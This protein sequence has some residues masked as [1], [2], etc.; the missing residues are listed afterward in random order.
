MSFL[1]QLLFAAG[2]ENPPATKPNRLLLIVLAEISCLLL[3]F[4]CYAANPPPDVNEAHYLAKAKHYW[5]PDWLA[6][7]HFLE[8]AD[9][10][11]VFYWTFGWLTLWFPLPVVAW[12]GRVVTWLGLAFAIRRMGRGV[13]PTPFFAVLVGAL[14]VVFLHHF[15]M[16]G[17][18]LIGGVEAKGFAFVFVFLALDCL[19]RK[20]IELAVVLCGVAAAFHVLVGGWSMIAMVAA[21]LLEGKVARNYERMAYALVGGFFCSLPGLLPAVM[22]TSNAPAGIIARANEIYVYERLS[23]HLVPSTFPTTNAFGYEWVSWAILRFLLLTICWYI[24]W[25]LSRRDEQQAAIHRFV[26][27][28]C[29]IAAAG[30]VLNA[31]SFTW[32]DR[33]ASLLRLYWFRLSDFAVPLGAAIVVAKV[34][35]SCFTKGRL[36]RVLASIGL[37]PLFL[38]FAGSL[39]NRVA[40]PRPLGD[41][42]PAMVSHLSLPEKY[43]LWQEWKQAMAFIR[44]HTPPDAR[45]I[46]P[47]SQQTFKWYAHR[48]EVVN[49]KDVPQNASALVEW[50]DRMREVFPPDWELYGMTVHDDEDIIRIGDKYGASYLLTYRPHY[51]RPPEFERIYPK[52]NRPANFE[53][54]KIPPER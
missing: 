23:H 39:W 19:V 50:S 43:E 7:D 51:R 38:S 41:Q 49:W 30:F 52:H 36:V 54:Y 35:M 45:F 53:L 22:L 33:G 12:V 42:Q 14:L 15:H 24:G 31:I 32:P 48:S 28:A 10:H 6:G 29:F 44:S 13:S 25:R 21:W 2:D 5:N 40:D 26:A 18:W 27:G 37:V 17:E 8:S 47:R 11:L 4:Y 9:A 16:A 20:R 46:T 1:Q 34:W 3:L